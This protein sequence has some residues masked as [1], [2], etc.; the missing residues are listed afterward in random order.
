MLRFKT[1]REVRRGF[2]LILNNMSWS[3]VDVLIYL[4]RFNIDLWWRSDFRKLIT[5]NWWCSENKFFHKILNYINY[6]ELFSKILSKLA[7]LPNFYL[8][9]LNII[10]TYLFKLICKYL[11]VKVKLKISWFQYYLVKFNLKWKKV[12]DKYIIIIILISYFSLNFLIIKEYSFGFQIYQ[13]QK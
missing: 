9:I 8:K 5:K 12:F 6:G 1:P 2:G 13:F 7:T 3:F 10:I 4:A 11:N